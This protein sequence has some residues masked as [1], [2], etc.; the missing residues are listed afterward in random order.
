[1]I[2]NSMGKF[3]SIFIPFS[4]SKIKMNPDK[5]QNQIK[6]SSHLI[7]YKFLNP[8]G[9]SKILGSI[10][11]N[12][13]FDIT[14]FNHTTSNVKQVNMFISGCFFQFSGKAFEIKF[15]F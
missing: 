10:S 4:N 9:F 8:N 15:F 7:L 5:K 13:N 6:D 11:Q 2:A 14:H 1:F 12:G 3:L